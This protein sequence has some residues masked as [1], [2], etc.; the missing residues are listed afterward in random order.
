MA[1]EGYWVTR[2]TFEQELVSNAR[3]LLVATC[4]RNCWSFGDA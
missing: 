2:M 3:V 4:A 1:R